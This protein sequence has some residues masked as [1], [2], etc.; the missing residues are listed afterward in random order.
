MGDLPGFYASRLEIG[1]E[2][3]NGQKEKELD[4]ISNSLINNGGVDET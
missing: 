4:N 1:L 2:N 3:K